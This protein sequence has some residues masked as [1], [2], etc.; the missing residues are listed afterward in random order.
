MAVMEFLVDLLFEWVGEAV[1]ALGLRAMCKLFS[2][3]ANLR[4]GT[5]HTLFSRHPLG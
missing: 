3:A 1:V 4:T 5:L 2:I